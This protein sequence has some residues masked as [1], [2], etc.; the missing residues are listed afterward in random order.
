MANVI[1]TNSDDTLY[2]TA[3]N[4]TIA[5]LQGNDV[6]KGF[7]GADVLEGH[8]GIDS[9]FYGDSNVGVTVN[10]FTGRG[11]GGSAE[12]DTLYN[13]ENLYGSAF[14]DYLTGNHLDN[15]LF[16]GAGDDILDGL[17][18]FGHDSLYGDEGNDRL[19]GGYLNDRLDGGTG[20]DI[21][22]GGFGHDSL[23]GDEGNDRLI[24]GV[25]NDKLDGGTGDDTLD[26]GLGVDVLIGGAG[27]D[28]VTYA[29]SS[30]GVLVSLIDN[31]A[32]NGDAEG[33]TFT[34][35]ENVIGSTYADQ[36]YGHDGANAINGFGGDDTLKGFGANDALHG[37]YGNDALLGMDGNDNLWGDNGDDI[38]DGGAGNDVL[39]GGSHADTMR[40]RIGDDI[41][42][43]DVSADVVIERAGEGYDQ[44]YAGTNYVL[45]AGS[46]VELLQARDLWGSTAPVDLVGNEF[47]NS[48]VGNYGQNTLVGSPGNDGGGYDGLDVMTGYGGGD[49]FVWTSTNET[50]LAGQEADVVTD[51]IRAEGDL[52]AF[53]LIDANTA[54]AGD[55][56]FT[57][58][59]I[60]DVTQG[61][62]FTA[63]GQIGYFTT[64]TDT[65]I[66]L[67]TEVDAGIDYQDAT[68]RVE[69]V[70]SVNASW[71]VL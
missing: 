2:G 3:E 21:L 1:G 28:T 17:T 7:G 47:G 16:G 36:L 25:Q 50:R 68:I 34:Y 44:V 71:F 22:D 19:I 10:L 43:V 66:L 51:F 26:G 9:A 12:G 15:S 42:F 39:D 30:A 54:V 29:G 33:D 45:A 8:D 11:Y 55:Q 46:H 4:D 37:G 65:Y 35:I 27:Y 38:L 41:Y 63:P 32:R 69:G 31:T 58:V 67:N 13:I 70:G 62:S 18:G 20:D 6:L 59:G 23:Y 52:L 64:S 60:V 5:A 48:L 56:A 61:G 49:V 24:G 14:N 57:F 40:G 53:N